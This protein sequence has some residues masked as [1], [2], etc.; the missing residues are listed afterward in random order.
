MRKYLVIATAAA[1]AALVSSQAVASDFSGP[2][3]ELRGGWDQTTLGASYDDG[4]DRYSVSG[5][6]SGLNLGAEV[7]YDVPT[8][9]QL[10]A[11]VYAGVEG[12]TAKRCSEVYGDDAACL[13]LGRNFTLGARVGGKVSPKVALYVKGGYS[14]GQLKGTYRNT[15]DPT[16]DF[17]DHTNR[18]GYH[19][20]AGVETA[21]GPQGYVRAEY[22]RTNY[23]AYTYASPD[24]RVRLSGHRD[25]ALAG[26]GLRF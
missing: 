23:N 8:N 1:A 10:L 14:N 17:S 3:F 21:V 20:G 19:F 5:H 4:A 9:S 24:F 16:L 25:Q 26:F 11:G 22:V 18:G 2:R 12:S 15:D 7:G 6:K 13:K